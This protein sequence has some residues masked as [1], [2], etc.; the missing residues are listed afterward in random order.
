VKYEAKKDL[1]ATITDVLSEDAQ[2]VYLGAYNRMWDEYDQESTGHLDRHE[3]A[4]RQGWMA[5]ERVFARDLET[6]T[7]HRKG[8]EVTEEDKSLLDRVKDAIGGI[9]S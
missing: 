2:E 8:D 5:V 7:W 4:H 6:G 3:V 1:P 9:A